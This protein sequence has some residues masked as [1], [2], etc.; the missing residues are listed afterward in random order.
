MWGRDLGQ[1]AQLGV[2]PTNR[3]Y[4]RSKE[5]L[6]VMNKFRTNHMS[7]FLVEETRETIF[8]GEL[9]DFIPKAAV[10]ISS[11]KTCLVRLPLVS[12]VT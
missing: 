7:V 4:C 10:L 2:V 5:F 8:P 11:S 6:L 9:L 12:V 1:Q 3:E